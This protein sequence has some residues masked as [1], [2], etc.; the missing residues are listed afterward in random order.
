M[1]SLCAAGP[2]EVTQEWVAIGPSP[3]QG[4]GLFA[5]TDIPAG[6]RVIEYVGEKISNAE[7][8][9]R[10]AASNPFIFS[11]DA[12]FSL[13]GDVPWNP[14]RFINH[15]CAPNCEAALVDGRIWIIALRDIPADTE[16]TFNYGYDLQDYPDHP[17]R[18]GAADCVGY[19]VDQ[20]F[21][22]LLRR[23]AELQSGAGTARAG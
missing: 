17:C 12:E 6:V 9:R 23:R 5:R 13:D 10:C 18:C 22:P 2:T 19:M 3:I 15:S 1:Q 20:A 4:Q 11:L 14:A 21:F 7:A 8:S 16:I